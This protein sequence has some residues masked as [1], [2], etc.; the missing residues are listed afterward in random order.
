MLAKHFDHTMDCWERLWRDVDRQHGPRKP[1]STMTVTVFGRV[2]FR[3]LSLPSWVI[4]PMGLPHTLGPLWTAGSVCEGT[5]IF[6]I[7]LGSP[8][9]R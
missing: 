2:P 7:D 4:R 5:L 8:V 6:T 1:S 9:L 3:Q